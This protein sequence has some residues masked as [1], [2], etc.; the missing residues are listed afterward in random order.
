MDVNEPDWS[1]KAFIVD[2]DADNHLLI[3]HALKDT[4]N[5]QVFGTTDCTAAVQ[6]FEE[7]QP[8]IVLMDLHMS[9]IS[10][11]EVIERIL[12]RVPPTTYL[13]ILVL[14]GDDSTES[15]RRALAMGAK[16]FVSK[17][18]DHDEVLLRTRNLLQTRLLYKEIEHQKATLEIRVA[19]RTAELEQA[20]RDVLTRLA[21]AAEYRDDDTGHHTKRVGNLSALIA[22]AAGLAND[23]V[24]NIRITA[25]LHDLGKIGLP[26]GI[27][28][29][30][31]LLTD[32]ER[33]TIR[34]HVLVGRQILSG[35]TSQLLQLAECIAYSHHERWDGKGYPEGLSGEA[36]PIVGR[37]VAV[38]DVF[39]ALLHPRP[40]KSAWEFA[41]ACNYMHDQSGFQFDPAMVDALD[42]VLESLRIVSNELF[43]EVIGEPDAEVVEGYRSRIRLD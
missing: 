38:A 19:E 21:L 35:S 39:D 18:A 7:I 20:Q 37:I 22:Q 28:L 36:I 12:A 1:A 10:G 25:P 24:E 27:L 15:K 30:P 4:P 29:K 8:D 17:F 31:G 11:F 32:F 23:E 34:Q 42:R 3:R 9:P 26:D 40:Y 6:M 13:P 2:D 33:E 41:D 43:D 16:D 14:T 5:I